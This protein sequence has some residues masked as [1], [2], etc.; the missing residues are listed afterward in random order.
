MTFQHSGID[1]AIEDRGSGIPILCLHGH[2]GS[3]KSMRVFSEPLSQ[4]YRTI[5]PDLRGY[6][7]SWTRQPFSMTDHL[8]DL[9]RLIDKLNID[10]CFILGWSLGGILAME[11]ALRHPDKIAGLVL[12]ATA[13]YP[14][15][16]LPL[17]SR[18]E[19]ITTLIASLVNGIFPGWQWNIETFGQHSILKYLL[20]Q[21]TPE[22]YRFLAKS[23]TSA[24]LKTSPAAH[25]ALS[26]AIQQGYNRL[27]DIPAIQCPCLVLA[28][29][30]DRHITPESS[31][32]TA[33]SLPNSQWIC[34]PDT[35]HLLP[36]EISQKINQDVS[37]W[38]NQH[39]A[40]D[41]ALGGFA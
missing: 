31:K 6:S 11:L 12:I 32:A 5:A 23:A 33:E 25:Q 16:R 18:Q 39:V 2:P 29:E 38:L 3:A 28:G 4:Q 8:A 19:L 22:S 35:A 20:S 1:L 34:Y 30:H 7:S 27:P 26:E 13:A 14:K 21:H 37:H 24:V 9:D 10:R 40:Q 36:W 41:Y 17:P 15:S